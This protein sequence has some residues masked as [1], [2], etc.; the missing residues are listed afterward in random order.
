MKKSELEKDAAYI[1]SSLE[2]ADYDIPKNTE[3][4]K[5]ILK[6]LMC[7]FLIQLLFILLDMFIYYIDDENQM[8]KLIYLIL[9]SA[10]SNVIFALVFLGVTYG[11]ASLQIILGK[12]LRKKSILIKLLEEKVTFYSYAL[13]VLNTII[14]IILLF[15]GEFFVAGLGFSWFVTFLICMLFLQGSMTRYMTPAV[16]SSL[17]RVKEIISA[18]AK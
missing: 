9:F 16:V 17:S 3:I 13:V 7:V 1:L 11:P 4:L 18:P 10:I 2:G 14:G 15:S 8:Y 6:K 5:V 12:E